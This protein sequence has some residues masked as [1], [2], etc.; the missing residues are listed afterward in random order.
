MVAS[1]WRNESSEGQGGGRDGCIS[2]MEVKELECKC[3]KKE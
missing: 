3:K 1:T 2:T